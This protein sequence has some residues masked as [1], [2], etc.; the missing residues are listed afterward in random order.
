[1]PMERRRRDA[2]EIMNMLHHRPI[3]CGRE[4]SV[5]QV[6]ETAYR[7]RKTIVIPLVGSVC[8]VGHDLVMNVVVSELEEDVERL[9]RF[10][11]FVKA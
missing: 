10:S 2:Y 11:G 9:P 4:D 6:Q 8:R 7:V 3:G 5:L 1:M